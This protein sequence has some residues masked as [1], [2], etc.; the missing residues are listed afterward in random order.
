MLI[1]DPIFEGTEHSTWSRTLER[2]VREFGGWVNAH[3]HLDR[4]NTFAPEYLQHA[5]AVHTDIH[6]AQVIVRGD[7][8]WIAYYWTDA[9]M[10]DGKRVTSRGKST[11][12]FVRE[13][14]RWLC[15][16][17]HYTNGP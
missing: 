17:G 5:K 15:I 14:G 12:I 2:T 1:M 13:N 8:A 3:T 6:N 16:H 7:V 9:G 4:A 11:R 10:V